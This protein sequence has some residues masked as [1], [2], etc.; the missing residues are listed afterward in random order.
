[1][2]ASVSASPHAA[3]ESFAHRTTAFV[4]RGVAEPV[5]DL[6]EVVEVDEDQHEPAVAHRLVEPLREQQP[7]GQP[8]QRVVVHLVSEAA[9]RSSTSSRSAPLRTYGDHL[10]GGDEEDHH[11]RCADQN[12]VQLATDQY[13][14][15]QQHRDSEKTDIWQHELRPVQGSPATVRRPPWQVK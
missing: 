10:S 9:L 13:V 8:G 12:R 6:L 15:R 3:L 11:H 4:A 14:E 5:V 7:V 1:M 2:R